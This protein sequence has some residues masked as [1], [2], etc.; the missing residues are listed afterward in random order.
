[1]EECPNTKY[2]HITLNTLLK[3]VQMQLYTLLTLMI[4]ELIAPC[5]QQ[6]LCFVSTGFCTGLFPCWVTQAGMPG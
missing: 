6:I 5:T 1:M 4:P 2:Y 3:W